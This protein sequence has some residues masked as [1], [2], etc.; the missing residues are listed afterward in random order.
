[1]H[2]FPCFSLQWIPIRRISHFEIWQFP[3]IKS[4]IRDATAAAAATT[5]VPAVAG[6]KHTNIV[7]M[8]SISTRSCVF[9]GLFLFVRVLLQ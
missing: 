4:I 2:D 5:T 8:K 7:D 6:K 9:P 1:M 3:S